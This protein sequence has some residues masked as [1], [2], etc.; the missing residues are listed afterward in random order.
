MAMLSHARRIAIM[1]ACAVTAGLAGSGIAQAAGPV[2]AS[3]SPNDGSAGGGT[4][5]TITGSGF[6]VGSTV[7]FGAGVGTGVSVHSAESITVTSPSGSGSEPVNITVSNSAGSS[8]STPKDQ[9]AFNPNPASS[10][11][12]LNGNSGG[13]PKGRLREFAA[14]GVVYDRGGAPWLD[15]QAGEPLEEGGRQSEGG[16]ALATSTAAGMIPDVTIEYDAYEGH[17]NS[18]PDFPQERTKAQERRGKETTAGYVEGF[19]ASAKAIHAKYPTAIF[20]PMNEPWGYTTPQYDAA[21]YAAVIARLLPEARAAG[22]P[23]SSIYVG[24]TGAS[25]AAPGKGHGHRDSEC[26]SDAWVT[27]MYAAQ[28]QLE[29][30]IEG[31]YVHPYGPPSGGEDGAG[32]QSVPAIQQEMT[33]GQ[34]NI[35]V[36]EAGYCAT[37]VNGGTGCGGDDGETGTEAARHLTEMLDNALPYHQAGWLRALLV[38]ARSAGGWAMQLSNGTLTA[39]GQALE[40]FASSLQPPTRDFYPGSAGQVQLT[41]PI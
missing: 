37:N 24:A 31:W 38:Y 14:K 25:C 7:R 21:E 12:G 13:A 8:P 36:S 9:F 40:S 32:I 34:N 2:V 27:A 30:E 18:D 16:L 15:W 28:P 6:T 4:P 29:T 23:L 11:L 22:I 19:I 33:S 1:L 39:Q 35:V 3:I 41:E 20:E 26:T 5:V 17:F 10:W